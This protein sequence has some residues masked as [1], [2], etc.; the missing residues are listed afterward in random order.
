MTTTLDVLCSG[1]T[2]AKVISIDDQ[3]PVTLLSSDTDVNTVFALSTSGD[4]KI[5]DKFLSYTGL[6]LL[7]NIEEYESLQINHNKNKK[8]S[9]CGTTE[10]PLDSYKI[11]DTIIFHGHEYCLNEFVKEIQEIKENSKKYFVGSEI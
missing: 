8:C 2:K 6:E 11:D 7:S 10:D 5:E 9:Y 4:L 1:L 3:I